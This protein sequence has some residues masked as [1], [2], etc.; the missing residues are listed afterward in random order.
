MPVMKR[1]DWLRL[2]PWEKFIHGRQRA[3]ERLQK[4][5]AQYDRGRASGKIAEPIEFFED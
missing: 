5:K 4:A 3:I 1:K 2:T